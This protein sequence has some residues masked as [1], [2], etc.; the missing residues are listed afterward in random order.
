MMT[1]IAAA[2]FGTWIMCAAVP[3]IA[4]HS[5]Q[6]TFDI[7]KPVQIEGKVT[8]VNWENPHV[9]FDVT[10]V[11]KVGSCLRGRTNNTTC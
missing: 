2:T 6:S 9:S 8:Q 5:F 1:K 10:V 11:D 4:H 7:D 3:L